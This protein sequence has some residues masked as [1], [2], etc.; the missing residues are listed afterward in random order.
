MKQLAIVLKANELFLRF[1]LLIDAF[2]ASR[3]V[4]HEALDIV[5]RSEG[6]QSLWFDWTCL[7]DSRF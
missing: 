5:Y 1:D 6:R 7:L 4:G 2:A 3:C